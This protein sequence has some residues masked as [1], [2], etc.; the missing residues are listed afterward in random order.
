M[1]LSEFFAALTNAAAVVTV[2]DGAKHELVKVN[3]AGYEQLLASLLAETVKE[4]TV[5]NANAV[6]VVL[7]T[8]V[9]A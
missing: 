7:D 4:I 1:L 9:S 6:T 3:V 5:Q 8:P 2:Q